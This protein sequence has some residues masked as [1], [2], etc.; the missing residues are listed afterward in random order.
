[1]ACM[2][3]TFGERLRARVADLGLSGYKV[4]QR[5]GISQGLYY[6]IENDTQDPGRDSLEKL[7]PAL[8]LPVDELQAWVDADKLGEER[9]GALLHQ[10]SEEDVMRMVQSWPEDRQRVLADRL[11]VALE[12]TPPSE[13]GNQGP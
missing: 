13:G 1:M 10:M 6:K 4:I 12:S 9:V 5:S 7:A 11:K 3:P 8:E 2:A